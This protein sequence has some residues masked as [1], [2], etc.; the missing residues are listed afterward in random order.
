MPRR[1]HQRPVLFDSIR[2]VII[3]AYFEQPKLNRWIIKLYLTSFRLCLKLEQTKPRRGS[4]W[5]DFTRCTEHLCLWKKHFW[6]VHEIEFDDRGTVHA[7]NRFYLFFLLLTTFTAH[8][9]KYPLADLVSIAN[10]VNIHRRTVAEHQVHWSETYIEMEFLH[11]C[12]RVLFKCC[13][14][15]KSHLLYVYDVYMWE[16]KFSDAY[17]VLHYFLLVFSFSFF[18]SY[19]E[20]ICMRS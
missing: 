9:L 19:F 3:S 14:L 1:L 12:F 7:P 4:I 18:I 8:K 17:I 15:G 2:M 5:L 20:H 10:E 16:Y 6:T 13:D 11:F